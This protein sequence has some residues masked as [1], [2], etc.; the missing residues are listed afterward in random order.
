MF[1]LTGYKHRRFR[2]LFVMLTL[3]SFVLSSCGAMPMTTTVAESVPAVNIAIAGKA[4]GS[5]QILQ[6]VKWVTG[7]NVLKVVMT[8]GSNYMFAMPKGTGWDYAYFTARGW[9]GYHGSAIEMS[10]VMKH[11]TE[12]GYENV[13]SIPPE[14]TTLTTSGAA[15]AL[16]QISQAALNNVFLALIVVPIDS[17]GNP[18]LFENYLYTTMD[19]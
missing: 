15:Q 6:I 11:L 19:S 8:D 14:I 1:Q 12:F 4:I 7:D 13:Q 9:V 10:Y 2:E 3:L 18:E 17:E 16:S 5:G